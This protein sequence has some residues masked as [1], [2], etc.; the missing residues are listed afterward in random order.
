MP[1]SLRVYRWLVRLYPAGFRERYRAPLEQQF[2]DDYSDVRGGF[3][4]LRFW[5]HTLIDFAIS[6]PPQFA[7]EIRQDSLHALRIWRRSPLHTAF[8]VAV[9]AIAIGAN[10]GVFSVLNALLLRSLPFHEP[11]R[12]AELHMFSAPGAMRDPSVFH[13][14]R[15]NSA[16]LADATTY[17]SS[18][19]NLEGT[20]QHAQ[21]V[22]LTETASNFFSLFGRQ[23]VL[24]RAF[25]SGEDA[26]GRGGVAVIAHGLWQQLFG[27][28]P[29]V[30]G[31][32]LRVNGAA[33]TIVGVAP[34]GFDY[35]QKTAVWSPT[36]FDFAHIPKTGVNMWVT[37]GRLAPALTWEQARQAFEAE[38]YERSP[39][40]RK[41]D[42]RCLLRGPSAYA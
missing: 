16:Y 24:G 7:R 21:R 33:L 38:A 8:A 11:E 28:D 26:Q 12:L 35:P 20:Q 14:W 9:L 31:S 15:Q 6:M 37:L 22:R 5:G 36:A 27:G 32:T 25:A 10:T 3:G 1:R 41:M 29:R 4:L 34:A 13:E 30:V 39:D 23:P 40:R 2:K 19:V 18:E 17:V 42:W